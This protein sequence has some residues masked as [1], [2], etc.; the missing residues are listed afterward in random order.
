MKYKLEFV[1]IGRDFK[2][3]GVGFAGNMFIILN[4]LN[5][6]PQDAKLYVDM[7]KNECVCTEKNEVLFG[8][9]NCW[10]YYFDQ[11]KIYSDEH[12]ITL[13]SLL[14]ATLNYHGSNNFLIPE[15]FTGLKQKFYN[16]FQLK[17]ELKNLI[18]DYYN[19]NIKGKTTLGVQ[20][21]LTDM[22]YHHN[23]PPTENY[24]Q[25][26]NDILIS[27]P[28]IQQIFL[29]TDDRRVKKKLEDSL[30]LP[31]IWYEEMFR[32]DEKN[33]H[34]NPYDRYES[35]RE[36]H[37]YILGKECIQEIFTLTKCDYLLKADISSISIVSCILSE[38]I[39]KIYML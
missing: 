4:A 8:T 34:N 1:K 31:I 28:E 14:P 10:E 35:N 5:S 3:A 16:S 2:F 22:K 37:R 25:K 30:F 29:A 23:V 20:I 9:K 17:S 38:N 6:I 19:K 26:I 39:K 18:D 32:A 15:N 24:I 33:H 11:P 12:L 13:N 7:E 21:R 27:H 36:L